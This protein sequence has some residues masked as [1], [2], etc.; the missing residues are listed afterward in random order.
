MKRFAFITGP[1]TLD[2]TIEIA[3]QSDMKYAGYERLGYFDLIAVHANSFSTV[4]Y[5]VFVEGTEDQWEE[6]MIQQANEV[7][8]LF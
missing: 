3:K 2:Q 5:Y 6:L 7:T 8:T 4:L 1:D